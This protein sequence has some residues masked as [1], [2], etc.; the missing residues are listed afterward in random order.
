MP[1][2]NDIV[3]DDESTFFQRKY[4]E[5]LHKLPLIGKIGLILAQ[6]VLCG[7]LAYSLYWF[8]TS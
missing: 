5:M 1:A 6:V 4:I 3:M 8:G 7:L 2:A